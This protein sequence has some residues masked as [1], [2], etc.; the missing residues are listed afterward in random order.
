MFFFY[1]KYLLPSKLYNFYNKITK[2]LSWR[3]KIT[4]QLNLNTK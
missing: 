2:Q 1:K 4:K 3:K